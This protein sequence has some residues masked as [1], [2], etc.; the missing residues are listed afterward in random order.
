MGLSGAFDVVPE[1]AEHQERGLD[2]FRVETLTERRAGPLKGALK[3]LQETPAFRGG[4]E[5]GAPSMVRI[6][7]I[8]G[9]LLCHERVGGSLDTLSRQAEPPRHPR[10][11]VAGL[12]R[13]QRGP[14]RGRRS[15][16]SGDSFTVNPERFGEV[17]NLV[18][19][20][21]ESRRHDDSLLPL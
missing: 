13:C 17:I 5:N 10:D 11:G 2:V 19:E 8:V 21:L 18:E 14:L 7:L 9:E 15:R 1:R 6:G 4:H 12:E 20:P 16:R 3:S